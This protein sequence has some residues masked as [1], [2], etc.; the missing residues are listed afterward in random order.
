MDISLVNRRALVGA[1]S[2]GI[3]LAIAT[4]LALSGASVTLMARNEDK[5]KELQSSLPL[6]A[7]TQQHA[8]LVVDFSDFDSYRNAITLF[9][10][11]H[12]I[13]I[14]VNNTNGPAPGT[15]LEKNISDYQQAFNQLFQTV[16]LTTELALPHMM[17]QGFGR[18]INVTSSTVKE[19]SQTLVLSNT[20]RTALVSWA[21][22]LSVQVAAAGV[23]VNNVLTGLF[24]TQRLLGLMEREASERNISFEDVKKE[25]IAR[26]PVKRLGDPKEYGYLV[27]FL[28]SDKASYLT[29][30]SI[31]LDGGVMSSLL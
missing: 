1:S 14:L 13:D 22:T 12:R 23:T 29:G 28:A 5:L 26:V 8:Y 9:F 30:T 19:P 27:T 16:V 20:M 24:E 6:V 31:Q 2:Q 11:N 3:G 17:K 7:E 4:E 25:R 21:K 15:A 10:E 18:I